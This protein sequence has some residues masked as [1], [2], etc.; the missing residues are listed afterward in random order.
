[1]SNKL[2][3]RFDNDRLLASGRQLVGQ[4]PRKPMANHFLSTKNINGSLTQTCLP[5]LGEITMEA[6]GLILMQDMLNIVWH[7]NGNAH[8][9]YWLS[10]RVVTA[11]LACL[12]F[13]NN[14]IKKPAVTLNDRRLFN[15]LNSVKI[16]DS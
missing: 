10:I 6:I 2:V 1:M 15:G 3:F 7:S 8:A 9:Q 12:P 14:G 5:Q 16:N 13:K 4:L 11:T